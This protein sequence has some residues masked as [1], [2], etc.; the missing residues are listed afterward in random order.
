MYAA[1]PHLGAFLFFNRPNQHDI[2]WGSPPIKLRYLFLGRAHTYFLFDWV[3]YFLKKH[4]WSLQ[5]QYLAISNIY[6]L[7]YTY[8]NFFNYLIYG[9]EGYRATVFIPVLY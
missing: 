5:P 9:G 2:F 1:S 7:H 4:G 3:M 8:T 6:L